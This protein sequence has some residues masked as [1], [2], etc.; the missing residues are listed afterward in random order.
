MKVRIDKAAL[1]VPLYRAYNAADQQTD[2][3]R[4]TTCVHLSAADDTLSLSATDYE[5]TAV[6]EVSADVIDGGAA[7]V[8]AKGLFQIVR[9]MPDGATITLSTDGS[10]RLRVEA[11]RSYYHLNGLAPEEYPAHALEAAAGKVLVT[12]KLHIDA[13]LK[14]TLFSVSTDDGRPAIT[15]VLFEIEPEAA[16]HVRLRMVSTD[17]HRLS[18]CERLVAAPDYDGGRASCIVHR[19]GAQELQRLIEGSDPSLRV[20][21]VGRNLV[22]ASDRTRLQVRQIEANFPDYT[23]VIPERGDVAVTLPKDTLAGAIRRVSTLGGTRS[24]PLLRM[25]FEVGRLSLE[26]TFPDKGDAHE[27]FEIDTWSGAPMRF[28][29]NPKFLLDVCNVLPTDNI[30]LEMRDQIS[31]CLLHSDEEPGATFVIMPMRL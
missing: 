30:T 14:R 31:P 24:D 26:M 9:A 15:G 28:G 11:G 7:L 1:M 6:A 3:T 4:V 13:M 10:H 20:E 5:I 22:F 8:S 2:A 21:F 12:D 27:E 17:G 19:R 16:G 18:K 23:K 25:E 29:F